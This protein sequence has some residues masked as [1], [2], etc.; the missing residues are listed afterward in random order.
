MSIFVDSLL[1]ALRRGANDDR[2]ETHM[3]TKN[4]QTNKGNKKAAKKPGKKA[5]A[6]KAKKAKKA[7][8]KAP[9][10]AATAK[11]VPAKE[12][13][14]EAAFPTRAR[15]TNAVKKLGPDRRA[16]LHQ[17]LFKNPVPANA[18]GRHTVTSVQLSSLLSAELHKRGKK[19]PDDIATLLKPRRKGNGEGRK[20][21]QR[22]MLVKTMVC[23]AKGAKT[24][25][26]LAAA[27][28]ANLT[29][30]VKKGDVSGIVSTLRGRGVIEV[31]QKEKKEGSMFYRC[32]DL[33]PGSLTMKKAS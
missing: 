31:L 20:P 26:V 17:Q 1:T 6:K 29:P 32:K 30:G 12:P 24:V 33:A 3:T 2:K 22:W 11:S 16:E 9:T 5:P 27:K 19:L 15:I 21:S 4:T 25:D 13:K 23:S 28:K 18:K 7:T 10:K 14:P 8:A